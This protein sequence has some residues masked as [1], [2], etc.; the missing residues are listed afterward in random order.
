MTVWGIWAR[1]SMSTIRSCGT[2]P[3]AFLRSRKVMLRGSFI[4][5]A[6]SR[7][8]FIV[9]MC[10][11]TPETWCRK[12]FWMDALMILLVRQ[13]LFRCLERILYKNFPTVEVSAMGRNDVGS[14]GSLP[15]LT[16]NSLPWAQIYGHLCESVRIRVNRAARNG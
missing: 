16:R 4:S 1:L 12:P 6:W 8:P 9:E 10:S 2:E 11:T 13:N 5:L 15:L 7:V 3:K 14:F